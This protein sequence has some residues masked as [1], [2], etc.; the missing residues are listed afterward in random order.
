MRY[1][2]LLVLP[3]IAFLSCNS[4]E[5][6]SPGL[7]LSVVD[8]SCTEAWIKIEH[9]SVSLPMNITILQNDQTI[10][11]IYLTKSDTIIYIDSLQANKNYIFRGYGGN[12][13]N[14]GNLS[15]HTMDSTS[16][17][18]SCQTWEI[19][20]NLGGCMMYDAYIFED[21]NIWTVGQFYLNDSLGNPDYQY[22]NLAKWDGQKWN[23]SR[24][25]FSYH[26]MNLP[27]PIHCIAALSPDDIWIGSSL[28]M[29]WDGQRWKQYNIDASGWITMINKIY[30]ES[31]NDVYICGE[32]GQIMHF[33][34]TSWIYIESHTTLNLTDMCI[35]NSKDIY[36]TGVA[37]NYKGIILQGN[38]TGFSTIIEADWITNDILFKEKLYGNTQGL[39]M[40]DHNTLY[41]AGDFVF[42]LKN[43]LWSYVTSLKGNYIGGNDW[44]AYQGHFYS[45][46]GD[47][48]NDIIMCGDRNTI[49]HFNGVSWVQLGSD[50]DVSSD[51]IWRRCS[52]K[53]NAAIC[54]G[55]SPGA[56]KAIISLFK[57]E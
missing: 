4:I 56:N 32:N 29:H 41:S 39:W 54:V 35:K 55:E 24:L 19:G 1:L 13:I 48:F 10:K 34:G 51:F 23:Y 22:Y 18:F 27:G 21:N 14:T 9:N 20:D 15:I 52:I 37:I 3:L 6:I 57:R 17:N 42:R 40:D 5:P 50:Y 8:V 16:H 36:V 38:S 43:G 30:I 11:N 2:L 47:S 49:R 33:D 7:A 31:H 45:I 28:P 12:N 26:D 25:L 53:N 46:N 44:A